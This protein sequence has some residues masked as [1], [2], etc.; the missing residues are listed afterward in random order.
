MRSAWANKHGQHV[1]TGGDSPDWDSEY[2]SSPFRF[3]ELRYGTSSF[4]STSV[5][6]IYGGTVVV[7]ICTIIYRGTVS[8]Y[9][10]ALHGCGATTTVRTSRPLDSSTPRLLEANTCEGCLYFAT[11]FPGSQRQPNIARA[12]AFSQN[13][14]GEGIFPS[15]C[16]SASPELPRG[17][18]HHRV[19]VCLRTRS[20]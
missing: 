3:G 9:T 10:S 2:C 7:H 1:R 11:S 20:Q 13:C 8:R 18:K 15:T 6:Y 4:V 16:Q 5:L 19:C 17:I 12:T 14:Q